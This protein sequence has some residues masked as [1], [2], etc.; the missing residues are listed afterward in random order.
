[1][2]EDF[3]KIKEFLDNNKISYEI[4]EHEPVY[5]SEDAAKI[6][7]SDINK[8]AKSMIV[9]SEGKFYN[10]VLSGAKKI[11]WNKIKK[12][13]KSKSASLAAPEEVLKVVN[14]KIGSVAPF[15]N[16]Y[17][18]KVYCD[19]FL[20]ENEFIEFNAGLHTKSIKMKSKDWIK[21]VNPEIVEFTKF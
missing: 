2:I 20:L 13:L 4:L 19:P 6:R 11:D 14:C 21:I 17:N 3:K 16:L 10:F 5:T 9:R 12:I 18:L 1:M 15:G 8:G 7:K